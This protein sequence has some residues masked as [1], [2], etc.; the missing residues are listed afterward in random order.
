MIKVGVEVKREGEI[1]NIQN[2]TFSMD[3][4]IFIT[5]LVAEHMVDIYIKIW[6]DFRTDS[7]LFEFY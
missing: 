5:I 3:F 7:S 2:Y 4:L 6:I 1:I